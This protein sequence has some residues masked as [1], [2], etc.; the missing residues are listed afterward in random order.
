M[1][2]KNKRTKITKCGDKEKQAKE[3]M[4]EKDQEVLRPVVA[5]SVLCPPLPS[6]VLIHVSLQP[7]QGAR[8]HPP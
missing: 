5:L 7:S 3:K 6:P 2:V 4:A 8:E 1:F